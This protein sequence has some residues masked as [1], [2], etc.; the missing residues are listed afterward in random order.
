MRKLQ[1][2]RLASSR[3]SKGRNS[4]TKAR[5]GHTAAGWTA[6]SHGYHIVG[7]PFRRQRCKQGLQDWLLETGQSMDMARWGYDE[8]GMLPIIDG[9]GS[10]LL[11]VRHSSKYFAC[12]K[13]LQSQNSNSGSLAAEFVFYSHDII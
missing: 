11:R 2:G 7:T 4:L 10:H 8:V 1:G 9:G 5:V 3:P 13:I 6:Y 12:F